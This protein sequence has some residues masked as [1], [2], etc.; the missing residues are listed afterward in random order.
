MSSRSIASAAL[1]VAAL[2]FVSAPAA[3]TLNGFDLQEALVDPAEIQRGGPPKDGI[4]AIDRPRFVAPDLAKMKPGERILGVER[5]GEAKAYPVRILNWHEVV[6]DSVGGEPVAVTYCPLCGSGVTFSR[7]VKDE[8]RSFGVSGLLYNSD[9][10][11]YDRE[12]N[13]LW[14]QILGKAVTGPAKG[15]KLA[16]VPTAHTSWEDWFARHPETLVL[17]EDTGFARDYSRD[18]YAGYDVNPVILFP[19]ANS[20]S[21]FDNKEVVLGLEIDG[22]HKAY[23][24]AELAKT[25]GVVVDRFAGREIRIA[26]DATHRTAHV[27]DKNGRELPSIMSYWFAWYAF[28]PES[29]VFYAR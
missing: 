11:L 27:L 24:F 16:V 20:S 14:S 26:Y 1:T 2:V 25:E 22:M 23:P 17:S 7:V 15:E 19:V 28:Y 5:N 29:A 9:V 12:S 3:Q 13:S 18:P 10:L 8:P 4:P 6:N 21:I